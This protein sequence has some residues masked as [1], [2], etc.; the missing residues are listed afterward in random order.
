MKGKMVKVKKKWWYSITYSTTMYVRREN[1]K[2]KNKEAMMR[3]KNTM[4]VLDI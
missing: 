1:I 3:E 4:K 2:T